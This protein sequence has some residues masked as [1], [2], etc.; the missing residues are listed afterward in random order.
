ML[1]YVFR[2]HRR[3]NGPAPETWV[4]YVKRATNQLEHL[5][6]NFGLDDWVRQYRRRKYRFAGQ[7][8]RHTDGRWTGAVVQWT[9]TSGRGRDRGRP[10]TRWSDDL[11][12]FAGDWA[13][14]ALDAQAWADA[15]EGFL[16]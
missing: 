10:Y 2:L 4:E 12:R 16:I 15:E 9:P 8:A 11:A 13:Q 5:A 1:R 3:R 14:E 6:N 7:V